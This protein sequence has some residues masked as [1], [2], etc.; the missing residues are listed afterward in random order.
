MA[1]CGC[2]RL[3]PLMTYCNHSNLPT[4]NLC[5]LVLHC[6]ELW[7]TVTMRHFQCTL[8]SAHAHLQFTIQ[9]TFRTISGV[10]EQYCRVSKH[11]IVSLESSQSYAM[12]HYS[13]FKCFLLFVLGGLTFGITYI[14]NFPQN[15]TAC[16]RE[17]LPFFLVV[18]VKPLQKNEFVM[19]IN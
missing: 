16:V 1:S 4:T 11:C 19:L 8:S 5:W 13:W 7:I 6:R 12:R 2:S 14:L 15:I 10:K 17:Y 18:F 9:D 3:W